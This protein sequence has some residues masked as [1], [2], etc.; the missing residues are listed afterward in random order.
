MHRSSENAKN[1]IYCQVNKKNILKARRARYSLSAPNQCMKETYVQNMKKSIAS[2]ACLKQ[3][4][5]TAF[6]ACRKP[7]A[8]KIQPSKLTNA[9][10]NIVVR[11][12]FQ[13][14]LEI[15]K[16]AVGNLLKCA[17]SIKQL[18][19]SRDDFGECC[20]DQSTEPFFYDSSYTMVKHA[21]IAVDSNGRCVIAE[22]IGKRDLTTN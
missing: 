13:R 17:K 20:H 6:K 21:T 7:L 9:V 1:K 2:N 11:R 14:V 22:E 16:M 3:K 19:L 15:R 10:A 5:L 18:D 12:L 4:L 8:D